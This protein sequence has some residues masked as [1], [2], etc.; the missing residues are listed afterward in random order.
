MTG[1]MEQASPAQ[2]LMAWLSGFGPGG[3]VALTLGVLLIGVL[4]LRRNGGRDQAEAQMAELMRAQADLNGRLAAMADVF[5]TRQAELNQ[6]IGQR[7]DGMSQRIGATLT[8]QTRHTHENLRRL[9]ERLA[10]I[11]AAQSNIQTL[12]KDVVGLQAILSNKQTRGAF[13]QARMEAIVADGLPMGAYAFQTTLSNGSRPDCTIRMPNGAP[14]LVVDAK[15][16]LEAWN[17]L[18]AA[19]SPEAARLATQQFRRDLD[20]HIRDIAQKYLVTGETQETAFLFVPSES[21]YA[22]LH[23]HFDDVV[24]RAHRARVMIVSPSL[25]ALAIQLMQS[26]IRDARMR[27]EARVIQTEVGKLLDDVRRL[28]ERVDKLDTHFRQAQDDVGQIKTSAGKVTNRAE[29]IGALD[30]DDEKSEPKLPF[31]KGLELKRAAE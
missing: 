30:F 28:G 19:A 22:D 6:S 1:G 25:L 23:E 20:T 24:Q 31:A 27:E 7:L 2:N 21:I 8:E 11:D 14:P 9:Q 26:L 18:R 16:P 29:K 5:G 3:L 13:G 12:A 15:F 17:A 10:V 4:F